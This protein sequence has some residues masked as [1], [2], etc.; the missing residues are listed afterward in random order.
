MAYA[1]IVLKNILYDLKS[2]FLK[3]AKVKLNERYNKHNIFNLTW[4][5]RKIHSSH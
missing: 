3:S 5:E 1:I 2:L 4:G